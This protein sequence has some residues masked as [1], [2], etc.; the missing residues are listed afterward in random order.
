MG[1]AVGDLNDDGFPEACACSSARLGLRPPDLPTLTVG[2]F[3]DI[4]SGTPAWSEHDLLWINAAEGPEGWR[5]FGQ[6]PTAACL[7]QPDP[8]RRAAF[9]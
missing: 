5:G 9:S 6:H 7:L 2:M 1:L 3:A 4:G 8:S